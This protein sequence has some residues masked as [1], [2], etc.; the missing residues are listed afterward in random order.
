MLFDALGTD[1]NWVDSLSDRMLKAFAYQSGAFAAF[2][3]YGNG[4][5]VISAPRPVPESG[6]RLQV[7][8]IPWPR[9][10]PRRL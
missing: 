6:C 9:P 5:A 7:V 3:G 1:P 2:C 8:E 10:Y 4:R